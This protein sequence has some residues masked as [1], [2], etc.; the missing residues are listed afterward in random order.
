ME[1]HLYHVQMTR[2]VTESCT[3]AVWASSPDQAEDKAYMAATGA[4]DDRTA[5]VGPWSL[6]EGS[7]GAEAPYIADSGEDIKQVSRGSSVAM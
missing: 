1:Q 6:N 2:D 5:H 7:C 4:A 3:V